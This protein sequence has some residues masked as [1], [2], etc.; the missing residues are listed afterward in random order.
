MQSCQNCFL[1]WN[2]AGGC[3]SK[4][5]ALTGDMFKVNLERCNAKRKCSKEYLLYKAEKELYSIK[6]K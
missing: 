6:T 5:I 4:T 2:C 1:K 3:H